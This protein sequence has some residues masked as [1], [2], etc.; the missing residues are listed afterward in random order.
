MSAGISKNAVSGKAPANAF[1]GLVEVAAPA[2][3]ALV[4]TPLV[5]AQLGYEAYGGYAMLIAVAA[6][7]NLAGL[8]LTVTATRHVAQY[9][10]AGQEARLA[11]FLAA[12]TAMLALAMLLAVA[13][14][15][16]G[17]PLAAWLG[18]WGG[19]N[20]SLPLVAGLAAGSL[21]A[22]QLLDAFLSACLKG[23]ER[24]RTLSMIDLGGRPGA[25]AA[26]WIATLFSKRPEICVL[27]QA[28]AIL[29]L[30]FVK[31][32]S[33][34]NALPGISLRPRFE[35]APMREVLAYSRWPWLQSIGGVLFNSVDRLLVGAILGSA[36]LAV[37]TVAVQLGQMAHNLAVAIFQQLLPAASRLH[38]ENEQRRLAG[39]A[40]HAQW[41]ALAL[42]VVMAV[43]IVAGTRTFLDLWMGEDF[44]VRH[45]EVV[46]WLLLAYAGL[47]ANTASYFILAAVGRIR[48]AATVNVLAGVA[49]IAALPT[50]MAQMELLG[51][52]VARSLYALLAMFQVLVAWWVMRPRTEKRERPAGPVG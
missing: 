51:T 31:L 1:W 7:G 45:G 12:C 13:C 23:G 50:L 4:F 14:L 29:A 11:R 38:A 20:V 28:A 49:M 52:A 3:G 47:A 48:E 19:A 10:N 41:C 36:A 15:A 34:Q 25:W 24:F 43:A 16:A 17:V 46:M 18:L 42:S 35:A 2:L 6:L 44:A 26:L 21:F 9:R 40:G 27:A 5:F 22:A 32:R 39:L 37:Y 30:S 8:G 33:L